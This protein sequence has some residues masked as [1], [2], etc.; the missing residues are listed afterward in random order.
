MQRF[1]LPIVIAITALL[2]GIFIGRY[3]SSSTQVVPPRQNTPSSTEPAANS[4]RPAPVSPRIPGVTSDST[5][6]AGPASSENIISKIQA[7][8]TRSGS[9]HTYATFSKIAE[10]VDATNVGEVLAFVQTLRKPQEKSMLVS[11]SWGVGRSSIASGRRVRANSSGRHSAKLGHYQRGRRLAEHDATAANT[12]AQQLP[13][14]QARDQAMQTIVSA[15]ADKDPQAALAFLETLPAGR[16]RQNLYWPISA[17]DDDRSVCGGGARPANPSR[18]QSRY[19]APGDR[20]KLGE[21]GS[22]SR[23][24]LGKYAGAWTGPQYYAAKY[25]IGL[26][27]QRSA[28]SR[29]DYF[30]VTG[31][32][33]ARSIN[34]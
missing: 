26:G 29:H 14:G 3:T 22:R 8:L 15:L 31:R 11:C 16:N 32:G 13:A 28:E 17:L 6:P 9:R 27:Q 1:A 33:A 21:P 2:T 23:F 20:C 4:L 7:A 30:G 25:F 19:R 34:Q 5:A 24:R 18:A 12:W 10:T